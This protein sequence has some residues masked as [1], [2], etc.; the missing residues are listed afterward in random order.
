MD[1]AIT[2]AIFLLFLGVFAWIIIAQKR[3]DQRRAAALE[4]LAAQQGWRI[5]RSAE[6][7]RRVIEVAPLSGGWRLKL[8][9]GY[10]TG[11]AKARTSVPGYSAFV[12]E[13]PAWQDGRAVFSQKLPGGIDLLLGSAGGLTGFFQNAAV[14]ALLARVIDADTLRDLDQL[15][16]FQAPAGIELS[17]LATEDPREGNLRAIHEGVHGWQPRHARD[18]S[19]PSVTIGPEGT[20]LRLSLELREA[21]DIAAFVTH[22]QALATALA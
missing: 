7:R 11:A 13:V 3:A 18:R 20:T 4:A 22:G 17:I 16:P 10:S 6:G 15:R 14:K 9:S 21:D 2:T 1:L 19:P 12:A 8:A 5:T